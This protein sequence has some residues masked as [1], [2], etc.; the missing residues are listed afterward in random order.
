M[1]KK[2]L[3]IVPALLTACSVLT[4]DFPT[5]LNQV[6]NTPTERKEIKRWQTEQGARVLF[7]RSPTLPMLDV[8]LVFNAG[9]ARDGAHEGLA[10]LTSALIDEGAGDLSV[11]DI[12]HG[13]ENLGASFSMSSHRDMALIAL[14]TLTDKEFF[15]P[16]VEL[17]LE[18]IDAPS[19]PQASLDRI[20]Q[21][22]L[23]GLQQ[24][25]QVPGPQI[26]R[27]FNQAIFN[28][29]PYAHDATGTEQSL[30]QISREQLV[31]FY[32]QYYTAGNV[33]IALTG[34][35]SEAQAHALANNISRALPQGKAAATLPRALADPE[36]E[37]IHLP[38]DSKQTILMLGQQSIWRGHP[39][40]VPLYVGNLILGGGGFS[41]ILTE[42]VR[43]KRGFVYAIGSGIS[44]M[45][46]A[47]P[48]TVRLQ[49]A[50]D[51]ADEALAVTLELIR[52]FVEQG[53]T[54]EQLE[55]ARENIIGSFPLS[56]AENDQI[57]SQ[58]GAIGFYNLPLDYLSWF[59]K[60]VRNVTLEQVRD[61]LR[62]NIHP[63][64]LA[65]VSIGPKAPAIPQKK[66]ATE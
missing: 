44:P 50:N 28:N 59:E 38:F 15:E 27:A 61:A 39:D 31:A 40:W 19:F 11:D 1:L 62:R 21:Q 32:Q 60:E 22:L 20:R 49:T 8:R 14:R 58:L 41:S 45:A 12:A 5:T 25:K 18:V 64:A 29:H 4:P 52:D 2:V 24:E 30:P 13:F 17:F 9:A 37:V 6:T 66:K 10:R 34:D 51:N 33:V 36:Q 3:I 26:Q 35:L 43:E 56:V 65:I 53:P 57:V 48:F 23:V 54:A 42:E 7:V 63:D 16:A 55:N 47:G 46:A